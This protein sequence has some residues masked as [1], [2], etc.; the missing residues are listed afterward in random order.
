MAL[1][2]NIKV[3]SLHE[4]GA[5]ICARQPPG[6]D[7]V[8]ARVLAAATAENINVPATDPRAANFVRLCATGDIYY[9]VNTTAAVPAADV[10]DGTASELLPAGVELWLYIKGVSTSK[11]P[12][13]GPRRIST[14]K[15]QQHA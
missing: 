13:P 6:P 8:N 7:S 11:T 15:P 4:P 12:A 9:N 3:L 1:A 10:T 14:Q 2:D 5:Y